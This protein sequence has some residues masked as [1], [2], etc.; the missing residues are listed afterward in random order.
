[1]EVVESGKHTLLPL[2]LNTKCEFEFTKNSWK[3]EYLF[4]IYQTSWIRILINQN[5]FKLDQI[6]AN[7]SLSVKNWVWT[8]CK[9]S[10][11]FVISQSASYKQTL[12]FARKKLIFVTKWQSDEVTRW[13]KLHNIDTRPSSWNLPER[14]STSS[15]PSSA[16]SRSRR[17]R[18]WRGSTSRSTRTTSSS[19]RSLKSGSPK[20][21]SSTLPL[22]VRAAVLVAKGWPT[23]RVIKNIWVRFV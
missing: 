10:K 9:F 21:P 4:A 6:W 13:Q 1:M 7:I 3:T 14:S 18:R 19:G 23:L 11:V 15:S 16:G 8:N 12:P 2:N 5:I 20:R 22:Q 17:P